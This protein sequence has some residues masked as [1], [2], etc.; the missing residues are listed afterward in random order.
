[1]DNSYIERKHGG[2][3][4]GKLYIDG[5]DLSPIEGAYFQQDGENYLWIKR[6]PILE[7]DDE[8]ETFKEREREPRWEAYLKKQKTENT[9]AYKGNCAFLRLKYS[10]SGVWDNILGKERNRLNLY[11]ERLPMNQ[12]TIINGIIKRKNGETQ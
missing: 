9:I 3:Y 8:T 2:K 10:I 12:Q 5:V 7:Y 6:K 1:M 11:V 4:E